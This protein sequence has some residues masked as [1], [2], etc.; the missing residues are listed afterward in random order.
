MNRWNHHFE[1]HFG[2]CVLLDNCRDRAVKLYALPGEFD[3]V[4]VTDGT[5]AWVAP[6]IA[7]P[8]SVKVA[9]LLGDLRAGRPLNI[10]DATKR[11]RVRVEITPQPAKRV[12]VHV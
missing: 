10:A 1:N 4:G 7:D 11:P 3:L 12:R 8:F 9:R 5:D 2:S 6:V